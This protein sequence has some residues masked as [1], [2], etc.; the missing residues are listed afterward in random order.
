MEPSYMIFVFNSA[1]I[2]SSVSIKSLREEEQK[3]S[4]TIFMSHVQLSR[5][6]F[7]IFLL[8]DSCSKAKYN[9]KVYL[10]VKHSN[11]NKQLNPKSKC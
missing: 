5:I 11:L 6:S 2:Y 9:K 3:K 4:K 1:F 10:T 8:A 7:A